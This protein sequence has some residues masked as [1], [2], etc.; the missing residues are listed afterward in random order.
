MKKEARAAAAAGRQKDQ[1]EAVT[2]AAE[3][4]TEGWT[5]VDRTREQRL[6]RI[7]EKNQEITGEVV[8][9]KLGEVR[10]IIYHAC[11]TRFHSNTCT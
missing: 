5:S 1:A 3:D 7:F 11:L 2:V 4:E 9:K 6:A 10:T 8:L